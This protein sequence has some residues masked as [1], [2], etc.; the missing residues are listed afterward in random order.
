MTRTIESRLRR[1]ESGRPDDLHA[2]SDSELDTRI[3]A[4]LDDIGGVAAARTLFADDPVMT[5]LLDDCAAAR[6]C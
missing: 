3:A 6:G 2:L 5:R 1:L 4:A